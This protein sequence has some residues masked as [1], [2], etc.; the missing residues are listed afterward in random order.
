MNHFFKKIS[1]FLSD[2]EYKNLTMDTRTF[3]YKETIDDMS[4]NKKMLLGKGPLEV[5]IVLFLVI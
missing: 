3:L 5:I 2:T 1:Y 4:L